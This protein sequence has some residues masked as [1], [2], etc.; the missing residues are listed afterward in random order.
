MRLSMLR[1]ALVGLVALGLAP[2][3]VAAETGNDVIHACVK[4]KSGKLRIVGANDTCNPSEMPLTWSPSASPACPAG[5]TL[6]IGACLENASRPPATQSSAANDCADEGRRLPST[7]ELLAFRALPGITLE[8]NGEW[9]D[10]VIDFTAGVFTYLVVSDVATG[11][12]GAAFPNAYRCVAGA[13][14]E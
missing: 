7:G 11:F 9:A 10:D 3:P 8:A 12:D 1:F 2:S 4:R 14:V 5:T 13:V 6:S